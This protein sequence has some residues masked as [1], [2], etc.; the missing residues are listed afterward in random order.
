MPPPEPTRCLASALSS[1][2][3]VA[4]AVARS[5]APRRAV[6]DR[7]QREVPASAAVARQPARQG[8]PVQAVQSRAAERHRSAHIAMQC[9]PLLGQ[10]SASPLAYRLGRLAVAAL[11][12]ELACAPKPGLVTPFD[13]GSHTDMDAA[14]FLR[15]LFALRGYFVAIAQAGIDDA[16]FARLRDLGIAAEAAM[17]RATG[18]VNTHRGAIFS[19]GLLTAQAA[20]LHAASD[21][22]AD[23]DAVCKGVQVWRQALLTA[24]LDP[25]SNGQRMRALHK[26][27]GVRE[28]AA[29]GYP[30]LRE[31]ALPTLRATLQAGGTQ[32][33]ALSQTLM[34]LIACVDDLN[35]LHRGGADGLAYAKAQAL[36]FLADGGT[37]QPNWH[38]RLSAIGAGFVE[39]RLSP[40]GSADL[41][42]C[43][44]FLHGQQRL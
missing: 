17:Q 23:A 16:P 2:P 12:A 22:P 28:Q 40:G 38:Q 5:A 39:R 34:Q 13:S 14:M 20:R 37:A 29:M 25:H 3:T 21:R 43:A 41:L 15:S 10:S 11:H 1:D 4:V 44:W 8:R 32:Q 9:I 36:R 31:V 42:A 33:A 6:P 19:L 35:L 26:V 24:P 18:G 7:G 27:A 30:V